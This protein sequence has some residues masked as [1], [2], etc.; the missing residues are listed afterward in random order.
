VHPHEHNDFTQDFTQDFTHGSRYDEYDTR[1]PRQRP[2][3]RRARFDDEP[4]PARRGRLTEAERL[5]LAERRDDHLDSAG[6]PPE[7]DRWSSWDGAEHGPEPHPGWLI[8]ELA[9]VDTE[10]GVLKTGK[11]ADVHLVRRAL[12][13][14]DRECLLAA[15]RYRADEHRMFHRDAGYLEGRRVRRSREMRA[16]TQRTAFGRN[17][18]AEQW[19]AAEF[20]ALDRLWRIGAPVPYPVQR[21]GTEVMLEFLGEPDGSAAPRL[22]AL[23]P[24][25]A[26]LADL[27]HQL[28]EALLA[29]AGEGLAHG[30]L[31][32]F[33][34]LVH[35]SRLVLIDLPQVVD[36]VAN[37]RGLEF[38]HRDV[39]NIA[40]WF[41]ARGLPAD[42]GDPDALLARLVDEALPAR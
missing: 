9:A 42:Q 28:T 33:N 41:A 25:R 12:P 20:S 4:E 39:R 38:L 14:T 2:R 16:M 18:L 7:G 32:A 13:G 37:P 6:A 29:L 21:D 31:S 15:K 3:T 17:L 35:R 36:L 23:R 10:L 22:A 24:A 40:S 27:W 5:R 8:T 19:A 1:R 34:L 11:E 30:D 26:E